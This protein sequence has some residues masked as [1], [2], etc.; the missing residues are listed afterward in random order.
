MGPNAFCSLCSQKGS[1]TIVLILQKS[2]SL[3]PLL[4]NF[5]KRFVKTEGK[6]KS[7]GNFPEKEEN[8][9]KYL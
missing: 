5:R 7:I 3:Y 4:G 1:F 2:F 9:K 8:S 6:C